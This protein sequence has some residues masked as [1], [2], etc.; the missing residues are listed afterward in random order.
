[1]GSLS[2]GRLVQEMPS[3]I[4]LVRVKKLHKVSVLNS[5]R[6]L[7]WCTYKERKTKASEEYFNPQSV[8]P[9]GAL[10]PQALSL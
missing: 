9:A 1:M 10:A 8:A 2:V 6:D 3:R 4:K 5:L 7:Y